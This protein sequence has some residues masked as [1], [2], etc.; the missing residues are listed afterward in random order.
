[1]QPLFVSDFAFHTP[2]SSAPSTTLSCTVPGFGRFFYDVSGGSGTP[3]AVDRA[4]A[5]VAPC[6]LHAMKQGRAVTF[7]VPV[8]ESLARNAPDLAFVFAAQLGLPVPEIRFARVLDDRADP[9][10]GSITGFSSGVDSWFTLHQEFFGCD[11]PGLRIRHLLFNNVGA[12]LSSTKDDDAY[13]RARQVAAMHGLPLWRVDSNMDAFLDM[14][15]E[16]THT[17]RNASV[18]HLFAGVARR[19]LYSSADTYHHTRIRRSSSMS[20]GDP[21]ILPLLSVPAMRLQSSGARFTRAEKTRAILAVPETRRLLDVCVWHDR[22]RATVN[23]GRCFKCV[24]TLAVLEGA[25]VLDEFAEA[26]DLAGYR[27]VRDVA[28]AKLRFGRKP[29]DREAFDALVQ[30]GLVQDGLIFRARSALTV[31]REKLRRV[32]R[33]KRHPRSEVLWPS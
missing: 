10:E 29:A 27:S 15:F 2:E 12:N 20:Y 33:G 7:D 25:D 26:F 16:E 5:F 17:A 14:D 6:L 19:F 8:S 23:C 30:A 13:G 9:A 11:R 1:M 32:R 4:D 24:R 21:V 31:A 18:A 22:R 28:V 3:L